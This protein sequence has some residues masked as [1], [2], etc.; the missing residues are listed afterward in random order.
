MHAHSFVTF[1]CVW[2]A[3]SLFHL[4]SLGVKA[5]KAEASW[6][7]AEE[8]YSCSVKASHWSL[9]CNLSADCISE[10]MPSSSCCSESWACGWSV[11]RAHGSVRWELMCVWFGGGGGGSRS[12]NASAIY[13]SEDAVSLSTC[14]ICTQMAAQQHFDRREAV[15]KMNPGAN[16]CIDHHQNTGTD[17]RLE[18]TFG[19]KLWSI[20][21]FCSPHTFSPL[22]PVDNAKKKKW[23]ASDF[24][25]FYSP[26]CYKSNHSLSCFSPFF[27]SFSSPSSLEA[28][29]SSFACWTC[30]LFFCFFS[31]QQNE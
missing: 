27:F 29:K 31:I 17:K 16:A 19:K 15:F 9:R 10:F 11:L 3:V 26:V 25:V 12:E 18:M 5:E 8:R 24:L 6:L 21:F 2:K 23:E 20:M 14:S 7:N 30:F 28:L 4:E 22:I 13:V 1:S